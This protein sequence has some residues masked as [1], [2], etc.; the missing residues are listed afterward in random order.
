MQDISDRRSDQDGDQRARNNRRRDRESRRVPPQH[1][2]TSEILQRLRDQFGR[3][4]CLRGED[5]VGPIPI[6]SLAQTKDLTG[7]R[8][9]PGPRCQILA[10]PFVLC[11]R[12]KCL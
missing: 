1:S 3:R 8:R 2:G 11:R 10:P 7:Q 12:Q 9:K 5:M 6:G 4:E